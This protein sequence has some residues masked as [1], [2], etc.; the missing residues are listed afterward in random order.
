MVAKAKKKIDTEMRSPAYFPNVR[1]NAAITS[2]IPPPSM[3]GISSKETR[4]TNAVKVHKRIVSTNTS[5]IPKSPC[6]A[7]DF[8]F[9]VACAIGAVPQPASL[10][11]SPRETPIRSAFEVIIP[12]SAP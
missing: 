10:D 5:K 4:I 2:I 6:F 12:I 9:V 11:I 7:G 3:D 1:E 8:A